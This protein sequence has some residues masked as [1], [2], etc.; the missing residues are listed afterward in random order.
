[1]EPNKF[2][3]D[4]LQKYL[5]GTMTEPESGVLFA[6]LKENPAAVENEAMEQLLQANY[7]ASFA[8][9]TALPAG[10][11]Q[12]I[13]DR[14]M[15]SVAAADTGVV[16]LPLWRR[17]WVRYAAAAVLVAAMAIPAARMLTNR[18]KPVAP[19]PV[20][21]ASGTNRAVLKLA[22][23]KEIMLDSTH[24][25]IVQEPGLT[26]QNDSGRL[27]YQGATAAMEYHTLTTPRGGQYRIT[28]PD[29]TAVWLNAA[30][31]I[32][33]P[34]TFTEKVRAVII[35]GEAYF[36][37]AAHARQPFRVD[38]DGKATVEVLG[39]Q[40]NVNAYTDEKDIRTTLVNG[41]VR[42]NHRQASVVLKPGQ[43]AAIAGE[44]LQLVEHPDLEMA[45]AW[46]NGSFQFDHAH[47]KEVLRQMARWYDVTVVYEPG[48]AD[49]IFSGEIKRDLDLPQALTVLQSMGVRFRIEGKQ[50]IVMP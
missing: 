47:L 5:D 19:A 31:S 17:P 7:D 50:L 14:L 23:G 43:Q 21:I 18:K 32:T 24:G 27:N 11:G 40:F 3:A 44:G 8:A 22:N 1:M 39:T 20:A 46:K 12:R 38:V 6:W 35:T 37:V 16:Q 36:E 29:G 48:S 13:L 42:V 49:I 33:Y 9:P 26:V 2:P 10:A 41:S 15:V 28:L 25:S 45:V 34:T 30:S 4:L